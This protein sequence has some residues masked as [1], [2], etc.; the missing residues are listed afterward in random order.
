LTATACLHHSV[1]DDSS[2]SSSNLATTAL[3]SFSCSVAVS[4]A[5]AAATTAVTAAAATAVINDDEDH[6]DTHRFLPLTLVY[7]DGDDASNDNGCAVRLKQ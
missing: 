4:V 6:S 3:Q 1:L 2:C 7:T 5:A